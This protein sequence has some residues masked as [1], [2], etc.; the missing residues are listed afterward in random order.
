[1]NTAELAL[2]LHQIAPALASRHARVRALANRVLD[3]IGADVSE[4]ELAAAREQIALEHRAP[5]PAKP[6]AKMDPRQQ[7]ETLGPKLW[8][9]WHNRALTHLRTDDTAYVAHMARRLPCGECTQHFLAYL[10]EHPPVFGEGYFAWTV[11]FHNHVRTGQGKSTLS[12]AEA[13]ALYAQ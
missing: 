6:A 10:H 7:M 2:A 5:A 8:R 11:E 9:E 12:V 4:A 3:A 1:M 13:R